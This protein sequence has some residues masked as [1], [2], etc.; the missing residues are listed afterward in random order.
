[1]KRLQLIAAIVTVALSASAEYVTPEQAL[2]RLQEGSNGTKHARAA[3]GATLLQERPGLYVFSTASGYMILPSDD[4]ARP[5]LAYGAEFNTEG[6]PELNYWLNFYA[7]EIKTAKSQNVKHIASAP[8][9][10]RQAIDPLV[11]AKWNQSEP[12]NSLCPTDKNGLSVTGCVAT[13]MAQVM[14]YHQWPEQGVG[15]HSYT[16]EH[17][18]TSSTLSFDYGAT[19]FDWANMTDIYDGNST[20]EQELAVATLMYAA[21]VS[22]DMNY[23]SNQSGAFSHYMIRAFIEN[24]NYDKGVWYAE[25][26]YFTSAEWEELIYNELAE[27][28]PVLYSGLSSSGGHQFVVDGYSADGY[29]HL[30]WGWGGVSNGYFTLSALNP[31]TLG[32]GAGAGGYNYG[33]DAIIGLQKPLVDSTYKTNFVCG[34]AFG[35]Q[36][37]EE[38]NVTS[39]VNLGGEYAFSGIYRNIGYQEQRYSL[40]VKFTPISYEGEPIE[41]AWKYTPSLCPPYNGWAA[42]EVI[43]PEDLSEGEYRVTPI[44]CVEGEEQWQDLPCRLSYNNSLI[45]T[46]EG[47]IVTFA[48][49]QDHVISISNLSMATSLYRDMDS[50]ISFTVTN[51]GDSEFLGAVFPVLFDTSGNWV[52]YGTRNPV[53]LASGESVDIDLINKFTSFDDSALEPGTYILGIADYI[54]YNLL[55]PL[56][57]VNLK[58]TPASTKIYLTD[59]T[60]DGAITDRSAVNFKLNVYCS[61]GYFTGPVYVGV[62]P[63]DNTG[64]FYG[65][66]TSRVYIEQNQTAE[67]KITLDLSANPAGEYRAIAFHNK[68]GENSSQHVFTLP[69]EDE[70][71]GISEVHSKA[72]TDE[73]SSLYDLLGRKVEKSARGIVITKGKKLR[74]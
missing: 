3:M 42:I 51:D 16:W 7:E 57:E 13:A 20:P 56:I 15:T 55:E 53:D 24:F 44:Y 40:G 8:R 66:A 14:Y 39:S 67:A 45:A 74:L 27:N 59:L 6:N 12:Y 37:D 61:E 2:A 29:F 31:G 65:Y 11:T 54:R 47:G 70:V 9:I 34:S 18:N 17:D 4:I 48:D 69:S 26:D 41:I 73:N 33:Q 35:M 71:S 25:R 38:G 21:G 1:M 19:T 49:P 23:S 64:S 28:R 50:K 36:V 30:N 52:A 10:T 63:A 60:V 72:E 5:I 43:I 58:E 22:V 62:V 46:V 32:I 68:N